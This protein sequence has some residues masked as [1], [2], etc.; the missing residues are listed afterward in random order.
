MERADNNA[1]GISFLDES[2]P[3]SRAMFW[4]CSSVIQ[5]RGPIGGRIVGFQRRPA[6]IVTGRA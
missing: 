2:G 1:L 4:L 5:S 6:R 3:A